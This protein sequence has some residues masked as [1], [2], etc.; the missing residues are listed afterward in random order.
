MFNQSRNGTR[1][2]S[3][4]LWRQHRDRMA[5][6]VSGLKT[7]ATPKRPGNAGDVT[8]TSRDANPAITRWVSNCVRM[9]SHCDRIASASQADGVT[10]RDTLTEYSR[11]VYEP[12]ANRAATGVVP[13]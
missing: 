9:P 10:L 7:P 11:S 8:V 4:H 5:L 1:Y 2:R 6:P 3:S 12:C 13:C